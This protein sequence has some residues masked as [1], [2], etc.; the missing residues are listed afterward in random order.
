MRSPLRALLGES[1]PKCS[2][3][4][5]LERSGPLELRP[6][7]TNGEFA[8]LSSEFVIWLHFVCLSLSPVLLFIPGFALWGFG[9]CSCW[10][11]L[12][13]V[14]SFRALFFLCAD[15]F[16]VQYVGEQLLARP[17]YLHGWCV[18]A[19]YVFCLM[20]KLHIAGMGGFEEKLEDYLLGY[21][22]LTNPY[23][24]DM[25]ITENDLVELRYFLD[26]LHSLKRYNSSL[27]GIHPGF[28]WPKTC[29][30]L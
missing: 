30:C 22:P 21:H 18:L 23:N 14:V 27:H 8:V 16:D 24:P 29:F 28:P 2:S 26:Q 7:L 17:G 12:L 20:T 19:E 11:V 6:D 10:G 9:L 15:I 3:C 25:E 4:G 13:I 5:Y 1:L